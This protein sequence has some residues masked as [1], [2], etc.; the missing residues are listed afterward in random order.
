GNY[1]GMVPDIYTNNYW[2]PD[3]PNAEFARP[4]K[5]DLRNQTNND[6]LVLDGS[7]LRFK[8]IQLLYTLP[9]AWMKR[10]TI[11]QATV[12]VSG[13][14]LITFS[15]LNRWHL[16]PESMSGVQNYYPQ[17]SMFTV[18]LNLSF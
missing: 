9:A 6:R 1:E 3:N 18:G 7:Y 15:K 4:T 2:T 8:N 17:V 5:Q 10:F 16:D 14:N 12:Y 13:T 11:S